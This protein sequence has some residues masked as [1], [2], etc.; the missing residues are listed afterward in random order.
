ME[1]FDLSEDHIQLAEVC[2]S[3]F[4]PIRIDP[5]PFYPVTFSHAF[6]ALRSQKNATSAAPCMTTE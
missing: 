4:I 3:L 2:S 6:T 1:V 5:P